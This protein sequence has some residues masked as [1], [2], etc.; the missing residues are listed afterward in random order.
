MIINKMHKTLCIIAFLA[1]LVGFSGE[2]YAFGIPVPFK[3][4]LA[5]CM[6]SW[7]TSVIGSKKIT[8]NSNNEKYAEEMIERGSSYEVEGLNDFMKGGVERFGEDPKALEEASKKAEEEVLKEYKK[9]NEDEAKRQEE[10]QQALA[11]ESNASGGAGDGADQ[12]SSGDVSELTYK[13]LEG[14]RSQ[15]N[16]GKIEY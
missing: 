8:K 10:E 2:A 16:T 4:Y 11:R 3:E 15:G 12:A 5:S 1:T 9:K 6:R 13:W 14:T 7:T